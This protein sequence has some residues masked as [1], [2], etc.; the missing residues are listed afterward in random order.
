MQDAAWSVL[1]GTQQDITVTYNDAGNTVNFVV[2]EHWLNESG[3]T[4]TGALSMGGNDISGVGTLSFSDG[5]NYRIYSTTSGLMFDGGDGNLDFLIY[6]NNIYS[7]NLLLGYSGAASLTTYDSNEDLT[8]DPNGIGDVILVPDSSDGNIGIG[9]TAPGYKLEINSADNSLN[10]SNF[11]FVNST[12]VGIGTSVPLAPFVIKTTGN[13]LLGTGG[14]SNPEGFV[15]IKPGSNTVNI[16]NSGGDRGISFLTS[17]SNSNNYIR[18][19]AGHLKVYAPNGYN[20][21]LGESDTIFI[22]DDDNVGIGTVNP[23]EKLEVA[24]GS[25]HGITFKPDSTDAVI[26]TTGGSNLTITSSGGNVIIKLGT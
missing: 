12:A 7:D 2:D 26:N 24:D 21:S 23:S 8:I 15:E 10:V 14:G 22:R 9:T 19:S 3:D 16:K 4:M 6:D 13:I 17:Q 5:A 20:M 1:G 25:G 11:L 18:S